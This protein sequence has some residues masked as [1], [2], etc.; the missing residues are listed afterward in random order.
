MKP[1]VRIGKTVV[2]VSIAK[3]SESIKKGL[4]ERD[5]LATERGML[6]IFPKPKRYRF[7]MK[8]M[9]FP[10]DIIWIDGGRIVDINENVSN[11]FNPS[12]PKFYRPKKKA[13]CVL[14]VNAGFAKEKNINIGDAVSYSGIG[15]S[16]E[17]EEFANNGK[18]SWNDFA[19]KNQSTVGT[20]LQTWEWGEFQ[21]NIGRRVKRYAI[22]ENGEVAAVFAVAEYK[23]PFGFSY[24]YMPRGPL[25]NKEVV[26]NESKHFEILQAIKEWIKKEKPYFIFLRTE[27][28]IKS[29]SADIEKYDFALPSYSVQPPKNTVVPL[30]GTEEEILSNF[31]ASTRSNIKR[32]EKR[33][34]TFE[35]KEKISETDITRFFGMINDTIVRSN[36]GKAYPSEDYLRK[37]LLGGKILGPKNKYDPAEMSLGI[38]FG[39][40]REKAASAHV[41]VFFGNTATYL[42]GAS[43]TEYLNSKVDT[44]LHFSAMKEAKR[45]GI[46]Y[47]DIGGIDEKI[48][49][50]LTI[51]KRQFG[52]DEICYIGN[53]DIPIKPFFYKGYDF[54]KKII[55]K[56][57]AKRS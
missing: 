56:L 9:L 19:L 51:F 41:V 48:W 52:G 6:F 26:E 5:S 27:P 40:Q 24:G 54:C 36:G 38:F 7:W 39:Y 20:F 37:F 3:D 28:S 29:V 21:K 53:I 32:A 15:R 46:R 44:Y 50:S 18:K 16:F 1:R 57:E 17:I 42:F 10:I 4:S 12:N 31:H 49:P 45:R 23:L 11:D 47:Y 14:E 34:V 33:G 13:D 8:G 35:I 55:K 22:K 2:P 25:L 43:H 30:S